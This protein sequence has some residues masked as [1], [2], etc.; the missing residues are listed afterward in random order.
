VTALCCDASAVVTLLVDAGPDGMWAA[1]VCAGATL[2]AP[3]LLPFECANII[4]RHEAAGLIGSDHAAQAHAD[5][6]DLA[7]ELW[8]Y[9]ALAARVWELRQN[10]TSYDAA[11]VALAHQLDAIDTPAVS[12]PRPPILSVCSVGEFRGLVRGNCPAFTHVTHECAYREEQPKHRGR[13]NE[14]PVVLDDQPD[15]D[16][17][18]EHDSATPAGV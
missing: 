11:Y 12:A 14:P 3:A 4:R 13:R 10:L 5:L 1:E 2:Y 6:L 9:E 17:H 15:K 18:A 8:P 7:V 16:Q